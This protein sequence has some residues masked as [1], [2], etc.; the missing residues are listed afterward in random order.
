DRAGRRLRAGLP[1]HGRGAA[2]RHRAAAEQDQAHQHDRQIAMSPRLQRLHDAIQNALSLKP[3]ERLG[4]LTLEVPAK[5]YRSV[6]L[7]LRDHAD[8]RFE[9]LID[10][11]GMDYETFGDR[12]REGGRFAVVVHLLSLEHNVRLRLRG[13][14]ADDELPMIASL[15]GIWPAAGWFERE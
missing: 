7:Q 11:C 10:L 3:V 5:D 13:T 6:A 8:L 14:C 15:T 1:A 2:L 12:P 9:T 4:E